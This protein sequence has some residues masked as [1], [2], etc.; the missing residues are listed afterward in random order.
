MVSAAAQNDAEEIRRLVAAGAD[1]NDTANLS[2]SKLTPLHWAVS[3]NN[4]EAVRALLEAGADVSPRS[5]YGTPLDGAREKHFDQVA[6]LLEEYE[7]RKAGQPASA[8]AAA[9]SPARPARS[10][11]PASAHRALKLNVQATMVVMPL[12]PVGNVSAHTCELLTNMLLT[13][14]DEVAGLKT[15]S[16]DDI[17]A[18]LDVEKQKDLLGCSTTACAAEMGGALGA[19]FVLRGEVGELGSSYNVNFSVIKSQGATVS[20]RASQRL[21]QSEDALADAL[22]SLVAEI[23]DK[24]NR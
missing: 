10:G 7:R 11:A 18:M 15:V 16:R 20:A 21:D 23:I 13:Q 14:L 17:E 22:P 1:P 6:A 19:D 3:R 8:P 5:W 12:K 24:L 9:P 2:P 4:L